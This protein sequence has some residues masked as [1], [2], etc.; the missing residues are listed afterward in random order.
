MP[1]FAAGAGARQQQALGDLLKAAGQ[2]VL[3]RLEAPA[4]AVGQVRVEGGTLI[5][6]IAGEATPRSIESVDVV[7]EAAGCK[8]S[9]WFFF[10]R[11][12]RAKVAS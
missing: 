9:C 3:D 6:H 5:A 2:A 4:V 1:A 10:G 8:L 12:G 11:S 7:R